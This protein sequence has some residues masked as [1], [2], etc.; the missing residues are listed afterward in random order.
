MVIVH[1]SSAIPQVLWF[2]E[3]WNAFALHL[4]TSGREGLEQ[5]QDEVTF[6]GA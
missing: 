2:F 5:L 1:Y 3:V 4:L 6:E